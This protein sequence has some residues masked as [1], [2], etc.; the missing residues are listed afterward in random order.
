[1]ALEAPTGKEAL[2]LAWSR[3]PDLVLFDPTLTYIP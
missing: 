3:E 1:V 2:I